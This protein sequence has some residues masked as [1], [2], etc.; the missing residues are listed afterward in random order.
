VFSLFA[1]IPIETR[2]TV[3]GSLIY[4]N[5]ANANASIVYLLCQRVRL[6]FCA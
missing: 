3:Q 2:P 1:K 5:N 4:N 6:L